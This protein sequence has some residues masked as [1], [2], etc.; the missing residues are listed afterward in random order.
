MAET[1]RPEITT[2][3]LTAQAFAPFGEVLEATGPADR[4]INNGRCRRHH[5]LACLDMADGQA[6]ISVFE[7]DPVTLPYAVTLVERHPLGS[8]A[9]LPMQARPFLVIVAEDQGGIPGQPRAFVTALGQ[10]VNIGRNVWHGPLT[11]LDE[12]ALFAVVDRCT[13]GLN[14][15]EYSY[16]EPWVVT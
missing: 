11:P 7:S 9:F 6:G 10:G 2:E 14:L 3:P 13:D 5:D 1:T 12:P 8:Q 16:S 4:L 15:E